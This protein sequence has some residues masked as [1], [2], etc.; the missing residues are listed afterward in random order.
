MVSK[1]ELLIGLRDLRIEAVVGVLPEERNAL[2]PIAVDI[3]AHLMPGTARDDLADTVDYGAFADIARAAAAKAP[4]LLETLAADIAE[5]VLSSDARIL[6][7][8]VEIRKERAVPG[9]AHAFVRIFNV[10]D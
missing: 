2:Q 6:S 9:A 10:R 1:D 4:Q 7:V 5:T 3:T 8:E